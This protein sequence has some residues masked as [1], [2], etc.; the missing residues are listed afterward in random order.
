MFNNG[1]PSRLFGKLAPTAEA[2]GAGSPSGIF[3]KLGVKN[4]RVRVRRRLDTHT[5]F[6][7]G[8]EFFPITERVED[9]RSSGRLV[10]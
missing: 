7:F 8:S 4:C 3:W 5:H 10:F 2:N 9:C 6:Q 1:F